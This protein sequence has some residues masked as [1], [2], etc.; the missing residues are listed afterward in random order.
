MRESKTKGENIKSSM[1]LQVLGLNH[2]SA[3]IEIREKIS[4]SGKKLIEALSLL[5]EQTA[6]NENLI[7]STCNRV[8][9]YTACADAR[10]GQKEI[11]KF[12]CDY[13]KID[14]G[15]LNRHLYLYSGLRA[16]EHLFKVTASLDSMVVGET[17]IL[18]QVKEAF[19]KAQ[20]AKSSG[21]ILNIVFQ[22][23]IQAGKKIRALTNI[24]KGAVS[25]SSAAIELAKKIFKDLKDKRI[26]I[27]GAGKIAEL[28]VENL[29]KKGVKTIIVANRTF[30]K[31]KEMAKIFEGTAIKF[32]RIDNYMLN[33]DIIISSTSAPHCLINKIQMRKI[34]RERVSRPMFIIDLGL[35]RNVSEDVDKINNVFLYNL[36]D[37]SEV[38]QANLKERLLEAQKAQ[39]LI[40]SHIKRFTKTSNSLIHAD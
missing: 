11:H 21:K 36:D 16:L 15:L 13:H 3:P 38:C 5:K 10:K 9:I 29:Y 14:R 18:G 20:E 27:I 6:L 24:G 2:K 19:L 7:L 1:H 26:L 28:A 33:T 35:P 8:E 40:S 25:V 32:N 12:L 30:D 34:M 23:A 22:E 37:L 17:Q 4:F 39:G 31:A